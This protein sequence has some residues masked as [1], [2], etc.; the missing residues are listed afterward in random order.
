MAV[1]L[2]LLFWLLTYYQQQPDSNQ[3]R[4]PAIAASVR[5]ARQQQQLP[6][7]QEATA[8]I[9]Y[10]SSR[11]ATVGAPPMQLSTY[12]I[13]SDWLVLTTTSSHHVILSG[14]ADRVGQRL[15]EQTVVRSTGSKLAARQLAFAAGLG[16]VS[17]S[18]QSPHGE[19]GYV[20]VDEAN[21]PIIN[22]LYLASNHLDLL[23]QH[24]H[25]A[26]ATEQDVGQ[27]WR[28]EASKQPPTIT[29]VRNKTVVTTAAPTYHIAIHQG[30]TEGS[31]AQA[32][33]L[34]QPADIYNLQA[35][36]YGHYCVSRTS[37]DGNSLVYRLMNEL[38][39][40]DL[41]CNS[42]SKSY[43]LN[44]AV[45]QDTQLVY[46]LRSVYR[47]IYQHAATQHG[48][49]NMPSELGLLV[50]AALMGRNVQALAPHLY[51]TSIYTSDSEAVLC[52]TTVRHSHSKHPLHAAQHPD[53]WLQS[54]YRHGGLNK[55]LVTLDRPGSDLE[56]LTELDPSYTLYIQG[57]E[58]MGRQ[59]TDTRRLVT[60]HSHLHYLE[61]RWLNPSYVNIT[62]RHSS[63]AY[64][65]YIVEQWDN[66]PDHVVF[67]RPDQHIRSCYEGSCELQ[68]D[69]TQ[70]LKRVRYG[71]HPYIPLHVD[72][73]QCKTWKQLTESSKVLDYS[74]LW[75][76]LHPSTPATPSFVCYYPGG[77][78]VLTRD[79]IKKLSKEIY[80]NVLQYMWGRLYVA[81]D[82]LEV[83]AEV[84]GWSSANEGDWGL[85]PLWQVMYIA[86]NKPPWYPPV[87]HLY[88]DEEYLFQPVGLGDPGLERWSWQDQ[89][90]PTGDMRQDIEVYFD[91]T[92]LPVDTDEE[93]Q[94]LTPT[95]AD[96][97]LKP[98]K[99]FVG[100]VDSVYDTTH[101]K[102]LVVAAHTEDLSWLN[103][104]NM[105]SIVY[106]QNNTAEA[107]PSDRQYIDA[108]DS[109]TYHRSL[110]H[111]NEVA[112]YLTYILQYYDQLPDLSFF[113]HGHATSWHS[114]DAI[115]MLRLVNSTY[116][117][118]RRYTSFNCKQASSLA[119][120]GYNNRGVEYPQYTA[121]ELH[122]RDLTAGHLG[123][124]SVDTQMETNAPLGMHLYT[125]DT[126]P[127][128]LSHYCCNQFAVTREAIHSYP[129]S[130]Y[131]DLYS[132]CRTTT[133][134]PYWSGRM[135]E[136][137]FPTMWQR[138][139]SRATV[140]DQ[141]SCQHSLNRVDAECKVQP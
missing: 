45:L 86:D 60:K 96:L 138:D 91:K 64:L 93:L 121:I 35:E 46:R 33:H 62:A 11:T 85:D 19:A 48:T 123:N 66:L 13:P 40:D 89:S 98:R 37:F 55:V 109:R 50:T 99:T 126:M 39:V 92:V 67:V 5:M 73:H 65:Y 24:T 2:W 7:V 132:W 135:F 25:T 112:T 102:A 101:S 51:N 134:K 106:K 137:L 113:F 79:A 124:L 117:M 36:P 133:L 69:K 125:V 136:H 140:T 43:V 128:L 17:S 56:W 83:P 110:G 3:L 23:Q 80:L 118:D 58:L 76:L 4:L 70:L 44:T 115:E 90:I 49:V 116:L 63:F 120:Q 31:F 16:D 8:H 105:P 34:L 20:T 111:C 15:T 26:I 107:L 52:N 10:S 41:V 95:Y 97:W 28:T 72:D 42:W 94:P 53:E 127:R 21:Q 84:P 32:Y 104:V 29:L 57:M 30:D 87:H 139:R 130:Y 54:P 131:T 81:D 74:H 82:G 22:F 68:R 18:R 59:L 47:I 61:Q 71:Q 75:R 1:L 108:D 141:C 27:I 12:R 88:D 14:R 9:L 129:K 77:E 122:W 119:R 78:F 103:E 38:H 6:D 114:G 100:D